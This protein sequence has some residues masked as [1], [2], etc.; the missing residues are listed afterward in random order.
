MANVFSSLF[1][2]SQRRKVYADLLRLDDHLLR[3]M[4]L[5]RHDVHEMMSG[6]GV[7]VTRAHE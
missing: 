6:R 3:D 5:T 4:G 7:K 1:R 2:R